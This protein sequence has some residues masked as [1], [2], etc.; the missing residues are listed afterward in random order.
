MKHNGQC[1]ENGDCITENHLMSFNNVECILNGKERRVNMD[2]HSS[3]GGKGK[4]KSIS[5]RKNKISNFLQKNMIASNSTTSN[6]QN[7]SLSISY[8]QSSC[9]Y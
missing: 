6:S 4:T 8:A 7:L 5:F 9:R 2:I 3:D 1:T